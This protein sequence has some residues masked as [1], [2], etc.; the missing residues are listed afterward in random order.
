MVRHFLSDGREIDSVEGKV[1][2]PTGETANAYRIISRIIR[3]SNLKGRQIDVTAE[4]KEM[5]MTL[6]PRPGSFPTGIVK[7]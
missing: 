7:H 5:P 3:Q 2:P 6:C 1:I 4:E